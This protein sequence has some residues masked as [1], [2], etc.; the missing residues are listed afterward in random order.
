MFFFFLSLFLLI[1]A[2]LPRY[3]P[4]P[5][6][7]IQGRAVSLRVWQNSSRAQSYTH[8][9][10]TKEVRRIKNIVSFAHLWF[11]VWMSCMVDDCRDVHFRM[12]W[13]IVQFH[14]FTYAE[15]KSMSLDTTPAYHRLA[16]E[17]SVSHWWRYSLSFDRAQIGTSETRIFL[18][19]PQSARGQYSKTQR[20]PEFIDA[21]RFAG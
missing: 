2:L 8:H 16:C 18:R 19:S 10:T 7:Q 5:A 13:E 17:A 11:G 6:E 4:Y 21:K 1:F 3:G 12:V 20:I 9:G 14:R 15:I